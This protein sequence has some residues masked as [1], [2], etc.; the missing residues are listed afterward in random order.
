MGFKQSAFVPS[1][2]SH[3][4]TPVVFQTQQWCRA[5]A[6]NSCPPS[7]NLSSYYYFNPLQRYLKM[8]FLD[9]ELFNLLVFQPCRFNWQSL[10]APRRRGRPEHMSVSEV[11]R[12]GVEIA[13][14]SNML[15]DL[16]SV[17]RQVAL[18][19][20]LLLFPAKLIT[21]LAFPADVSRCRLK[22]WMFPGYIQ[23]RQIGPRHMGLKKTSINEKHKP[24][25]R[26]LKKHQAVQHRLKELEWFW[27]PRAIIA[28]TK[29][30]LAQRRPRTIAPSHATQPQQRANVR[31]YTFNYILYTKRR[32]SSPPT[33]AKTVWWSFCFFHWSGSVRDYDLG[34]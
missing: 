11:Y 13:E 4:R 29:L 31:V 26:G 23:G 10:S 33:A 19:S 27:G 8:M 15:G 14:G 21:P 16:Y 32:K 6:A 7:W 12:T 18:E 9:D 22:K 30:S 5:A 25:T 34:P 28:H 17:M 20:S 24:R 3:L 1:F 2:V